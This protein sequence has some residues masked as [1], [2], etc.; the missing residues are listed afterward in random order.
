MDHN[1]LIYKKITFIFS[2]KISKESK[3]SLIQTLYYQ[4][5]SDLEFLNDKNLVVELFVKNNTISEILALN[6]RIAKQETNA[7]VH[8]VQVTHFY[9][10]EFH[11]LLDPKTNEIKIKGVDDNE[12]KK[13]DYRLHSYFSIAYDEVSGVKFYL[14]SN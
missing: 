13:N 14:K 3:E 11:V 7:S 2:N 6:L 4:N 8:D 12:G 9:S 5:I 1:L 10:D